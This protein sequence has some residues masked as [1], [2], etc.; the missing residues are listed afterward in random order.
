MLACCGPSAKPARTRTRAPAWSRTAAAL[1]ADWAASAA[2]RRPSQF[3]RRERLAH[4]FGA[5]QLR[6]RGA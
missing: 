3:G 6:L 1:A 2:L 5:R 4:Q